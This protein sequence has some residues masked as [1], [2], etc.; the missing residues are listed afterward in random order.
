[1]ISSFA[2]KIIMRLE[3]FYTLQQLMEVAFYLLDVSF[4]FVSNLL[5]R[6]ETLW[7]IQY[8]F[9]REQNSHLSSAKFEIDLSKA[10]A[11]KLCCD[12]KIINKI[13]CLIFI[14]TLRLT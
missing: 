4:L 1:M 9:R 8:Q 14:E 2:N 11:L 5:V 13:D 7:L 6:S 3:L 12:G 10:N